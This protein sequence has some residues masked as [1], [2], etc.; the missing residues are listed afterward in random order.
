MPQLLSPSSSLHRSRGLLRLRGH[1]GRP[2]PSQ[3]AL[4]RPDL[5]PASRRERPEG[6]REAL[7]RGGPGHR[8]R[9]AILML[10]SGIGRELHGRYGELCE[11]CYESGGPAELH[12]GAQGSGPHCGVGRHLL[13]PGD[14]AS[15]PHHPRPLGQ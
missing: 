4:R 7:R 10:S 14:T 6:A 3:E 15:H 2:D 1:P 11:Q 9:D 8:L 5:H 12:E 13:P